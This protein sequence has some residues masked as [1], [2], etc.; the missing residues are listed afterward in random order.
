MVKP[1]LSNRR[2]GTFLVF[3]ALMLFWPLFSAASPE[4]ISD[5]E[6]DDA[7]PVEFASHIMSIDYRKG[8]LV[9]AEN[10]VMIVDLSIGGERF[11]TQV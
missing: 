5:A 2:T 11:K 1:H 6:L 4:Y 7:E 9:V 10:E 8:I 3:V